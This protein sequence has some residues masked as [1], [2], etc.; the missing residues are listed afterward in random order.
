MDMWELG[1]ICFESLGKLNAS[2]NIFQNIIFFL[3]MQIFSSFEM[4]L[5]VV[6]VFL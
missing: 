5:L 4:K 1:F 3:K 6:L 2:P